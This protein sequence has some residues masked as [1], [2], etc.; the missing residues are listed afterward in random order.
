MPKEKIVM[1]G[2][3]LLVPLVVGHEGLVAILFGMT[4]FSFGMGLILASGPSCLLDG[5]GNGSSG[6]ASALAGSLQLT[7]ASLAGLLVGSFHDGS[8]WPLALT[9]AG[10][11][12]IGALGY[13]GL[14]PPKPIDDSQKIAADAD[15]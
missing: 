10:F 7:A 2:V 13:I 11:T 1:G 9:I 14:R 12:T 4:I 8:A 15:G 5:A 6:S 3:V